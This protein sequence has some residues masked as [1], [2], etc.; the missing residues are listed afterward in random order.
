M[1]DSIV[2]LAIVTCAGFRNAARPRDLTGATAVEYCLLVT[3]IAAVVIG[4]VGIL[5]TTVRDAFQ[6]M[7]DLLP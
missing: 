7:A 3:M 1:L 2:R 4:S 6:T 5:G